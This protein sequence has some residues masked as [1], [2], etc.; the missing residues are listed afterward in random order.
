[1]NWQKWRGFV[2]GIFA[3]LG[4]IG[5]AGAGAAHASA[6]PW[7]EASLALPAEQGV[8]STTVALGSEPT[9]E[10]PTEEGVAGR[11]PV[12]LGSEPSF[13]LPTEEGVAAHATVAPPP[14]SEFGLRAEQLQENTD[15]ASK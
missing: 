12:A 4:L 3:S 6:T 7:L 15:R 14:T 8:K 13:E 9:F 11:A 1:M 2:V 10:L 5:C